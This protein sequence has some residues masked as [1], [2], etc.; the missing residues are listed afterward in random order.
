ML[1]QPVSAPQLTQLR[2][3]TGALA[4]LCALIDVGLSHPLGQGHRVDTE[5]GGDLF[6]RHPVVAVAGDP[7]DVFAE[8]SGI[9][10]GHFD[11]LSAHPSRAGQLRC[12]L[13]VQ[14]TR[15]RIPRVVALEFIRT[16]LPSMLGIESVALLAVLDAVAM[17]L[18][19]AG[20]FDGLRG[21]DARRVAGTQA[22]LAVIDHETATA[23]DLADQVGVRG[24]RAHAGLDGIGRFDRLAVRRAFLR[25][26]DA[27]QRCLADHVA[28]P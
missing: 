11:V 26:A 9:G 27:L 13:F 8:L 5:V 6:D 2:A 12:H 16:G 14:Q 4:G 28:R 3:V 1:Q 22:Y 17:T 23:A 21:D 15:C 10:P 25:A 7:H 20:V 18:E 19:D 24:V